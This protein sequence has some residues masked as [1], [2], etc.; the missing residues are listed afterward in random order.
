[1][2]T[3]VPALNPLLPRINREHFEVL[4][5]LYPGAGYLDRQV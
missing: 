1:V 3:D 2:I 4:A 5:E